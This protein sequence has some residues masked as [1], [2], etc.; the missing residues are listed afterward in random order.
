LSQNAARERLD[1]PGPT[2]SAVRQQWVWLRT[3]VLR[4]LDRLDPVKRRALTAL[5]IRVVGAALA[6]GTQILLAQWMGLTEYGIFVAVWVWLLVLCGIAPLGLSVSAI[7]LLATYHEQGDLARW[8]GLLMTGV[9]VTLLS[10]AAISAAGLALIWS[11]PHL[12]AD[13]Y[14]MPLWL[15]LFCVPLFALSEINEGISRAHGWMNTALVPTY[16]LRPSLLIVGCFLALQAGFE[17]NATLAM[18]MA[19]AAG[20]VTIAVQAIV[21]LARLSTIGGVFRGERVATPVTWPWPPCRSSSPTPSNCSPRT[22]T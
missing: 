13:A 6:Y 9:F 12:I 15:C 7:G 8:R 20:L 18:S 4:L 5:I 21:L 19:I 16:I 10:G 1:A 14:L 17:L 22:S 11:L 2:R 3:L